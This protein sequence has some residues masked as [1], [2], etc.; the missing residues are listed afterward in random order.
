MTT[1]RPL[2]V[3]GHAL[4][5]SRSGCQGLAAV[6]R[7]K[8]GNWVKYGASRQDITHAYREHLHLSA[9]TARQ[10]VAQA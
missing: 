8:C 6:G 4:E 3:K 2:T 9:K 7:C 1:A 5:H 10:V